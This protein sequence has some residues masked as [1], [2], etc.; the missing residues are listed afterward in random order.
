MLLPR[1]YM[2]NLSLQSLICEMLRVVTFFPL[3]VL[4]PLSIT[5]KK[6]LCGTLPSPLT[7]FFIASQLSLPMQSGKGHLHTRGEGIAQGQCGRQWSLWYFCSTI[8]S[9]PNSL[10]SLYSRGSQKKE[11]DLFLRIMVGKEVPMRGSFY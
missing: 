7:F 8:L 11:N 9:L 5:N 4:F 1:Q 6:I 10:F 2:D 3:G